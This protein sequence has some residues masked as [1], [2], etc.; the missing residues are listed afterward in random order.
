[1]G[2]TRKSPRRRHPARRSRLGCGERLEPRA[3]LAVTLTPLE[4]LHLELIN[5]ARANPLA[6]ISRYGVAD[7]NEGLVPGTIAPGPKQPLAPLDILSNVARAHSADMLARN[8][9]AHV[10]PEGQGPGE[11]ATA[12]GY[13]YQYL[14]EN[15]AW[16]NY[17]TTPSDQVVDNLHGGLIRSPHHREALFFP[18]F[19]EIGVGLVAGYKPGESTLSHFTTNLFG[20]NGGPRYLTGVVYA[21]IYRDDNFYT[22]G[23]GLGNILITVR[24][25]TGQVFT[26]TTG[27]SGGYA[28]E[29]PSGS[30][31]ITAMGIG[32][33]GEQYATTVIQTSNVKVD[34]VRDGA[35]SLGYFIEEAYQSLLGRNPSQ[36]DIN[37]WVIPASSTSLRAVLA[38]FVGSDEYL[39]RAG[40]APAFVTNAY[41]QV[42]GRSPAPNEVNT[43]VGQFLAGLPRSAFANAVASSGELTNRLE[44]YNTRYRALFGF[45]PDTEQT[46][47]WTLAANGNVPWLNTLLVDTLGRGATDTERLA[48]SKAMADGVTRTQVA[49]L[50]LRSPERL[51]GLI[52]GYYLNILGRAA[53]SSELN[54]WIGAVQ[55]G[56]ALE[57]VQ[58]LLYGSSEFL[59]R[60]GGNNTAFVQTLYQQVLGR[61]GSPG[62]WNLWVGPLNAGA[63][64]R[65]GTATVF[66]TSPEARARLIDGWYRL[67]LNRPADTGGIAFWT[68]YLAGNSQFA[69]QLAIVTSPEYSTIAAASA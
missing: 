12:A 32:L 39:A 3:L 50:F 15:L 56:A 4:Q 60:V 49:D 47:A 25:A 29:L 19:E 65:S 57:T 51:G 31:S 27:P 23:E 18:N 35:P 36:A 44:S 8:Y 14:G 30:Y 24:S 16:G 58:S 55:N 59:A 64:T 11:R 46:Y 48:W 53:S 9:F 54:A 68:G 40:S 38:G 21:D 63:A 7:L 28:L 13:A 43:W 1:M 52:G 62:E 67:Y 17:G 66:L 41:R 6:A 37:A 10:N 42:L 45:T 61:Q 26:T 5:Q 69:A 33:L 2:P 34:F 20:A 22:P